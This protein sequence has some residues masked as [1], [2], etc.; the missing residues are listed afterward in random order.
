M[1]VRQNCHDEVLFFIF[2]GKS[3]HFCI[4]DGKFSFHYS[5]LCFVSF[6][7]CFFHYWVIFFA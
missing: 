5:V 2:D 1:N 6:L 3:S 4:F 7:K